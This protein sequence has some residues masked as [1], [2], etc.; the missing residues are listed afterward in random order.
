MAPGADPLVSSRGRGHH[1]MCGGPGHL[2][3]A[4]HRPS[5]RARAP[6]A[7]GTARCLHGRAASPLEDVAGTGAGA[8]RVSAPPGFKPPEPQPLTV[9]RPGDLPSLLTG[10]LALL[11]RLASGV[12]V[13]GWTPRFSFEKPEPSKYGL[14]LGPVT[15]RDTSPILEGAPRPSEPLVLYEYEASPFCRKVREVAQLLDITVEM[16]PCPGARVGFAKE[17][18][19]RGGKMVVPYLVDP[20]TRS[21][22]Y[23]SEDIIDYLLATYGPPADKYDAKALWPMRGTFPLVT[24]SY[25][26]VARGFAGA[27]RQPDARPD[28]ERMQPLELWGYEASPF[29]RPVREKLCALCLPHRIVP[30]SRGSRNRDA[31]IAKTGSRFQVPYLVDPNTGIDLFESPEILEYLDAV[32]TVPA[33]G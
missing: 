8:P 21:E 2:G 29:V 23:E 15:L 20:N 27:S 17:L 9:T 24:G 14:Q 4:S 13:L 32:Y 5:G 10:S 7:Q 16:R 26:A 33:A 12:F 28:N 6:G 1:A 22:M 31:L 19:G 30:C 18:E 25:A 3:V 11:L